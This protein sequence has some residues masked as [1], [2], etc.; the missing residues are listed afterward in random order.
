[1]NVNAMRL[2][3]KYP[4]SLLRT[5][6]GCHRVDGAAV[7]T[8]RQK[9]PG[10][11]NGF[12]R[13]VVPRA[14]RITAVICACSVIHMEFISVTFLSGPS[15]EP[16]L[17]GGDLVIINKFG[18]A[19]ERGDVVVAISPNVPSQMI[20]KRI[21]ATEGDR[22]ED[23]PSSMASCFIP[24]GHV[25]LQGD[26]T[27]NSTDSREYGPVPLGLIKGKPFFKMWPLRNIGRLS[28]YTDY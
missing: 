19:F 21:T 1:M 14:V 28:E 11:L 2:L 23:P 9:L 4:T 13:T 8:W 10:R 3:A 7:N 25:W 6:R 15:M 5:C 22:V 17:Q 27:E 20:C 12:I 24:R 18:T 26:N 16:I